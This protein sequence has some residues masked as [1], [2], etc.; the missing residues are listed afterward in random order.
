M[1]PSRQAAKS[2]PRFFVLGL[3]LLELNWGR[4]SRNTKKS[5]GEILAA[6]RDDRI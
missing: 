1:A 3:S 2:S 5:D 6:W 4:I